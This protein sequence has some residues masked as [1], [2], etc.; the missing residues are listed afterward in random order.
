VPTSPLARIRRL[1]LALPDTTEKKSWGEPTFRVNGRLFAMYAA[2]GNHHGHGREAVWLA[3]DPTNQ[4]L[5]IADKPDR[6]F[7]PAYVGPY[8]WVGVYL[9]KRPNWSVVKDIITD[10]YEHIVIK[11]R[12]KRTAKAGRRP[13]ARPATRAPRWRGRPL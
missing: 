7:R 2:A 9:D 5:M 6:F 1:C 11:M 4:M 8:G 3:C 13:N 10:A 12:T